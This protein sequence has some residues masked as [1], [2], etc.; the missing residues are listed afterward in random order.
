MKGHLNDRVVTVAT[1][2]RDAGYGTFL[3]GKWHLGSGEGRD[4][5]A[6]GFERSFA[7]A[8]GGASHFADMRPAYAPSPEIKAHYTEDGERLSALPDDFE[9]SSQYYVDRMIRY[10]DEHDREQTGFSPSCLLPRRIGRCRRPTRPL[11]G[12]A[13]AMTRATIS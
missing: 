6:R 11:S 1:L 4:P 13:V 12:T 7:L 3:T 9:Y 5:R 8:S 10:L 2:F